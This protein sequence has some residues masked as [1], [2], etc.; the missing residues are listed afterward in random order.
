MLLRNPQVPA[1]HPHLHLTSARTSTVRGTD[2]VC[3]DID[4]EVALSYFFKGELFNHYTVASN[5]LYVAFS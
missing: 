5:I 2:S 4:D 1:V 3:V